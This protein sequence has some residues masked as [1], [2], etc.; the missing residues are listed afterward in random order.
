MQ[1]HQSI[2]LDIESPLIKLVGAARRLIRQNFW[3]RYAPLKLTP[4]QGWVLRE[5]RA[6]GPLSLH[7]LAQGVFMDDPTACRVVKPLH[8]RGLLESIPDPSHGRRIVISLSEE[9]H[10]VAPQ[11]DAIAEQLG[12]DLAAGITPSE[13]QGLRSGLVKMIANLTAPP[14]SR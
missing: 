6:R 2:G 9:G 7:A 10:R 4:Q 11:L 13:L 8:D 5:L 12:R 1:N 3:D 14:P